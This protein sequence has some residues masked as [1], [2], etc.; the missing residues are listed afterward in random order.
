MFVVLVALTSI[1]LR[2]DLLFTQII[3]ASSLIAIVYETVHFLNRTN[4]DLARLF[5]SIKDSD[6]SIRFSQPE[7]SKAYQALYGS[8]QEVIEAFKALETDKAAQLHFLDKL[9]DE[10]EFGIICFGADDK[11][12]VMNQAAITITGFPKI[13]HWQNTKSTS[14]QLL[15]ELTNLP[16][17]KNQLLEIPL[18]GRHRQF[19]VNKTSITIKEETVRIVAIQDIRNEIQQKEIEAWH[20]LIS[21]LTHEIMNTVTPLVSLSETMQLI[22]ESNA[23]SAKEPKDIT[24]ENLNDLY[25]SIITSRERSEGILQFV[26]NYRKLTKIPKPVL[27]IIDLSDIARSVSKL[28]ETQLNQSEINLRIDLKPRSIEADKGLIEQVLIN[29]IKNAIESISE[30]QN[31]G[32]ID[33]TSSQSSGFIHLKVT[34]DGPGIPYTKLNQVFVPF[35]TSK[36]EGSGI[37]L[38]LSRQIMNLHGGYLD[39]ES[40]P[41]QQTT[42]TMAFPTINCL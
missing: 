19:S 28:L 24:S 35:Y 8:F 30:S 27:E 4:Q 39:L 5:A 1:F 22:V 14:T 16:N 3:L 26:K 40:D 12:K 37:G 2:P 29:L 20:R 9:I 17:G 31:T 21:I 32:T 36:P 25:S 33:I 6:F 11:I 7:R 13:T 41:H 34:D 10:I 42:F 23:G 38:S 15:E 18:R